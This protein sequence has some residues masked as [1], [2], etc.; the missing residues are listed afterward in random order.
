MAQQ[1]RLS[2]RTGTVLL[3]RARAVPVVDGT[4][5]SSITV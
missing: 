5:I 2:S 3:R 4:L 1:A